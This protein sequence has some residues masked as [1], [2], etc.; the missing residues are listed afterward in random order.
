ML[1]APP[2]TQCRRE[3][4]TDSSPAEGEAW[5]RG[6]LLWSAM[7]GTTVRSTDAEA[8]ANVV[9]VLQLAGAGKLRASEKTQRPGAATVTAVAEVL[10]GGDFYPHEPTAALPWPL[11][12]QAGRPADLAGGPPALAV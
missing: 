7:Q 11:L 4:L 3:V 6:V 5:A 9:A 2:P 1:C 12:I 8:L 10:A